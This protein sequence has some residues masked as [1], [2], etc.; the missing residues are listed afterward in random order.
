M[1]ALQLIQREIFPRAPSSQSECQ[2]QTCQPWLLLKL[3]TA[4]INAGHRTTFAG[5]STTFA[6]HFAGH[7]DWHELLLFHLIAVQSAT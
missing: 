2:T 3:V 5:H 6:G 7:S 1:Q 4:S